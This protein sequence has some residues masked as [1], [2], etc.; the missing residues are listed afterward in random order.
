MNRRHMTRSLILLSLM[1]L[2]GLLSCPTIFPAAGAPMGSEVIQIG[3]G[4]G[5]AEADFYNAMRNWH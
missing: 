4:D 3:I 2:L 5:D 1:F